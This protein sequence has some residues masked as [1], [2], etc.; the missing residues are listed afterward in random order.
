MAL[1]G[2]LHEA[3]KVARAFSVA[4]RGKLS[5]H[6]ISHISGNAIMRIAARFSIVEI[7]L[8]EA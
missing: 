6:R 2:F 7:V 4:G 8:Q 1:Q 3:V 5:R